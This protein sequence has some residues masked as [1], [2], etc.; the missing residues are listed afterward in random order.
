MEGW[1]SGIGSVYRIMNAYELF[2]CVRECVRARVRVR[3]GPGPSLSVAA[4]EMRLSA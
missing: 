1:V 4:C 3:E 2:A